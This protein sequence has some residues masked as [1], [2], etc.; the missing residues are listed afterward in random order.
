MT[1]ATFDLFVQAA[2]SGS[3]IVCT[4]Q[5]LRR[6]ICPH[7]IGWGLNGDEMSLSY[8]FAGQSSKGLPPQGEWRC[9]RLGSVRDAAARPGAWHSAT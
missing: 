6:E 9:F 1:S 2:K 7:V 4:Y 5:A 3:Q 8:Q